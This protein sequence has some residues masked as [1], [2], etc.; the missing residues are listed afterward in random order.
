M[1]R[2]KSATTRLWS[3]NPCGSSIISLY[4]PKCGENLRWIKMKSAA[5]LHGAPRK[6]LSLETSASPLPLWNTKAW[7]QQLV[8]FIV[9][10]FALKATVS[11]Y[12]S[13]ES[14]NCNDVTCD[15]EEVKCSRSDA[16][17]RPGQARKAGRLLQR[18]G[19]L[20][21]STQLPATDPTH[22]QMQPVSHW[23][24]AQ[25]KHTPTPPPPACACASACGLCFSPLSILSKLTATKSQPLGTA[26]GLISKTG[27]SQYTN[28][29]PHTLALA[30]RRGECN[31]LSLCLTH[32][33]PSITD[34]EGATIDTV[35]KHHLSCSN[36]E[37]VT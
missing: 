30:L 20:E 18:V 35:C 31:L 22:R 19:R 8:R 37:M 1:I 21:P 33:H 17:S 6:S 9:R 16:R 14:E 27:Q 25:V 34:T 10:R 26:V 4:R 36:T 7:F 5:D 29:Q 2:L 23:R 28:P 11:L 12:G 32:N 15:K 13:A 24:K 3:G